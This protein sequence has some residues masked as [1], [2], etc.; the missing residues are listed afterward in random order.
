MIRYLLNIKKI[1]ENCNEKIFLI[2]SDMGMADI[3]KELYGKL[4]EFLTIEIESKVLDGITYVMTLK[5]ESDRENTE[6]YRR[7]KEVAIKS[8][9]GQN[10]AFRVYELS[11]GYIFDMD[12]AIAKQIAFL[13][14]K[15]VNQ[16]TNGQ[17]PV[18]DFIGDKPE[19]RRQEDMMKLAKKCLNQY[20]SGTKVFDVA[21]FSRNSVPR[22]QITAKDK[23]GKDTV[24]TYDAYAVRHWD[25]EEINARLLAKEGIK[26]AKIEPCE[27]LPSKT[28]VRFTLHLTKA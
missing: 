18:G 23:K 2:R 27:V 7:I 9:L 24:I 3:S 13:L 17:M 15:K 10:E 26:I 1:K 28:G 5:N 4:T 19:K 14:S 16:Q 11:N 12:L 6:K 25:I 21:L 20:K 8:G 22:I